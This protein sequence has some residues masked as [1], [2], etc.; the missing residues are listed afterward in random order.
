MYWQIIHIIDI[1]LWI[2][3]AASVIYVAFFAIISIIHTPHSALHTDSV[4]SRLHLG[5]ARASSAFHSVCT[6][7]PHSKLFTSE[8]S[9]TV[10]PVP[11][12]IC[13]ITLL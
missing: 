12:G 9:T 10:F 1:L 11:V 7:I 4:D 3:I 8:A 13:T 2:F 6:R 5:I